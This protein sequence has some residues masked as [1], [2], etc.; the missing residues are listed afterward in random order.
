VSPAGLDTLVGERGGTLSGGQ[1]QR[2]VLGRALAAAPP[3]LVLHDPT[4]AVDAVTEA[5]IAEGIKAVRRGRTTLVV[6]TSPALLAVTDRVMLL[7]GGPPVEGRHA[8][9]LRDDARYQA[10]VLA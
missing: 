1:R 6:A 10:V 5:R 2:V 3:V 9:L 8:A 4:T 7:D